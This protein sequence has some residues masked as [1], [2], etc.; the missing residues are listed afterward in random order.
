MR[1]ACK[2]NYVHP[3]CKKCRKYLD[4][5]KYLSKFITLDCMRCEL[6]VEN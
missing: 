2:V 3:K 4:V 1:G 5:I 6:K